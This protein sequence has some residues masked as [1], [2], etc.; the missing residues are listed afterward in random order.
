ML[1]LGEAVLMTPA[2]LNEILQSDF[3]LWEASSTTEDG[4]TLVKSVLLPHGI[5]QFELSFTG[6]T[7]GASRK[8][9]M[10]VWGAT[11]RDAVDNAVGDEAVT[12]RAAQAAALAGAPT[13]TIYA[14]RG[15]STRGP[16]KVSDKE[17]VPAHESLVIP[18]GDTISDLIDGV[19][20]RIADNKKALDRDSRELR[21]LLAFK[22]A[23]DYEDITEVPTD[24]ADATS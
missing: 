13:D 14:G 23:L 19:R 12:A 24:S 5:G 16:E 3:K 10:E 9:A 6:V 15:A 7:N 11:I 22:E 20:T 8:A 21:A 2:K 1:V 17:T 18:S 4:D